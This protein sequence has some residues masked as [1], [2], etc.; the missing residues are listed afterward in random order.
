[1]EEFDKFSSNYKRILDRDVRF[2]G[3]DSEYFAS[4]KAAYVYRYLGGNFNGN[5][6]DYGCGIGAVTKFLN[7][8]FKDRKVDILGYDISA[9][10]IEE[11]RKGVKD[12]EFT[13]NPE[14]IENRFF[15]VIVM[16]NVL[17]HIKVED[18]YEFL[19][20][21]VSHLAKNGKIFVF[22]HNPYNP[23]ARLIVKLSILD[24]GASLIS[25]RDMAALFREAGICPVESKYIIFFP[26]IFKVFRPLETF[27]GGFPVGAQY[28][29]V[30][31][32]VYD[33]GKI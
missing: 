18:R 28:V 26:K 30:G 21:A 7:S 8:I 13:N 24:R 11:A 20:K 9:E 1:M 6:L 14:D 22:E 12:V 25:S 23:L 33:R 19:K 17:H 27:L 16:A 3:E 31:K 2:F 5:I 32:A 29:F 10:S 15:D 4:Y